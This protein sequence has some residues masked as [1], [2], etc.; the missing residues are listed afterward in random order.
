LSAW[1]FI[2]T[3]KPAECERDVTAVPKEAAAT[4]LLVKEDF[5]L[6]TAATKRR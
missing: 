1:S 2:L 4:A 6:M 3:P 5:V